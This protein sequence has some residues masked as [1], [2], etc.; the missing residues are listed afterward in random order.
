MADAMVTARMAP[1]KKELVAR[2]LEEL[3]TTHSQF[4]NSCY[5]YVL[6]HGELPVPLSCD[7]RE[8]TPEDIAAAK[9]WLQAL[10]MSDVESNPF[11]NMTLKEVR[12][13]R[14]KAKGLIDEGDGR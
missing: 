5:D 6:E 14:L 7:S 13:E 8:H 4:I 12:R 1:A 3:G 11:R 2:K 9:E 10:A